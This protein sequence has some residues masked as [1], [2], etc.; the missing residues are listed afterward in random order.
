M[1]SVLLDLDKLKKEQRK[2]R[3]LIKVAEKVK[4]AIE[5]KPSIIDYA[6]NFGVANTEALWRRNLLK[7]DNLAA[8]LTM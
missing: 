4:N 6:I 2:I 7:N 8:S 1:D 5:T 3:L